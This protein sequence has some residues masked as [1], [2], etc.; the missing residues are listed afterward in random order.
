MRRPSP[1]SPTQKQS[2]GASWPCRAQT[3]AFASSTRARTSR[4]RLLRLSRP[5]GPR[6]CNA[7]RSAVV[8]WA[9]GRLHSPDDAQVEPREVNVGRRAIASVEHLATGSPHEPSSGGLLLLC[10][11]AVARDREPVLAPPPNAQRRADDRSACK[12][13]PA[14]TGPGVAN[15]QSQVR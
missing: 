2:S 13:Q 1:A 14:A 12:Q 10:Q 15:E 8:P 9:A 6:C 3:A 7:T 4:A 5:L 11:D